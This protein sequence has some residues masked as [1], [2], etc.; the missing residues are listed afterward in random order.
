MDIEQRHAHLRFA[1]F[2][3]ATE[4]DLGHGH[5]ELLRDQPDGLRK[6][7]VLDFLHKREHVS[8][9]AAS[10]AV[11]EL[12]RGVHGE[13][14]RLLVMKRTEA[15]KILRARLL[16]LDVVADNANDVGLLLERVFEVGGGHEKRWDD[17][18]VGHERDKGKWP[19][20]AGE[21]RKTCG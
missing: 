19:N 17:S 9:H 8:R 1:R 12:P 6:R 5:A 4:L 11:K 18:I 21:V 16:E 14:R 2:L 7:N 15:G 13:R 3:R 10:E 20:R